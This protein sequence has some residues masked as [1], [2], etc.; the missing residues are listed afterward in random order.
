MEAMSSSSMF[1]DSLSLTMADPTVLSQT[2][3]DPAAM[4]VRCLNFLFLGAEPNLPYGPVQ[5]TAQLMLDLLLQAVAEAIKGDG[6]NDDTCW[7]LRMK[8]YDVQQEEYPKE[9]KEWDSYDGIILPG[10]FS[11]AYDDEPWIHKLCHVIQSEIV[12]KQRKTLGI[13][14]GHQVMAHSFAQ[15]L[16]SKMP[17]G[18]RAGRYTMQT[19]AAGQSLLLGS[20]EK[21]QADQQ[22]SDNGSSAKAAG[23]VD[24]Y[25]THGDQVERLPP[26]AVCLGGDENVPILAAAYYAENKNNEGQQ[27]QQEKEPYAIT[28]Q[29]HPEYASS[30]DLGLYRTLHLIMDAMVQRGVLQADQRVEV[31]KDATESFE[32]VRRDSFDTILKVGR[33]FKWFP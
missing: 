9:E 4:H 2:V 3:G 8:M 12:S 28:F 16:A 21:N 17:L 15:G 19:T 6:N 33:I 7:M 25:Y 32:K 30:T 29:A 13:C 14:F 18:S 22:N 1:E 27:E 5:H 26:C 20:I 23:G 10:S 11:A 31:G 24:Y